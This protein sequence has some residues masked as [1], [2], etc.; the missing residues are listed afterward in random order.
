[1]LTGATPEALPP[2][3][4]LESR[5]A[6]ACPTLLA[7]VVSARSMLRTPTDCASSS[8]WS[9]ATSTGLYATASARASG[10][11]RAL[12]APC[13]TMREAS[14]T[15]SGAAKLPVQ[16]PHASTSAVFTVL[17]AA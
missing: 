6:T 17:L 9:A 15:L 8:A 4:P 13:L 2:R 5:Q 3:Q 14:V 16:P 11:A 10:A 12:D 7:V 1:M